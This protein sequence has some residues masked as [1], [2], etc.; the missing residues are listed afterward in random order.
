MLRAISAAA[1]CAAAM[2]DDTCCVWAP[3]NCGC[4][5]CWRCGSRGLSGTGSPR[6]AGSREMGSSSRRALSRSPSR[7]LD[8]LRGFR[9]SRRSRPRSSRPRSPP[10]S[11]RSPRRS[12]LPR[13]SLP[14]S[15]RRPARSS[16]TRSSSRRL[17]LRDR[18]RLGDRCLAFASRDL[19]RG[20]SLGFS[21]SFS[22]SR[23]LRSFSFSR[24]VSFSRRSRSRSRLRRSRLRRSRLLLPRSGDFCFRSCSLA[25]CLRSS[26]APGSAP[27]AGTF[28]ERCC[29]NARRL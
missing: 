26:L 25:S 10:P 2:V 6:L 18:R 7:R 9:S 17:R 27:P 1:A 19:L 14:R 4:S 12:S 28:D 22:R 3:A 23:P 15:S 5:L 29:S 16:L 21:F 11:R 20:F 24:A 8:A 13:S